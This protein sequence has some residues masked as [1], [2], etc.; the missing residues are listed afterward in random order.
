MGMGEPFL[1]S[2]KPRVLAAASL[3]SCPYGGQIA[4]KAITISTVGIVPQ[5]DE[6]T[7]E[8]YKYRL[9]ISLGAATDAK[10]ARLVPMAARWPVAEVMAAARRHAAGAARSCHACLRLHGR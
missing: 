7:E 9:S 2:V 3:L 8:G 10:R 5:I 4:A 1:P 6:Y